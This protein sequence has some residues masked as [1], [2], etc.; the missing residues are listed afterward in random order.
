VF[1][2]RPGAADEF[3]DRVT[4]KL[5]KSVFRA[6][7]CAPARSYYFDPHG[8]ASLLRPTST[9]ASRWEA[10]RFPLDD[11]AFSSAATVG[12]GGR[13]ATGTSP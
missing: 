5:G 11:Y 7:N 8:V 12:R 6:G 13:A 4:D 1:E 10:G 3:L 9:V 2:V